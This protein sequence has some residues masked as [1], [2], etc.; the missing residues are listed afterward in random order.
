MKIKFITKN[1][2]N[3]QFFVNRDFQIC[4]TKETEVIIFGN[5]FT[6]NR[7]VISPDGDEMYCYVSPTG[8]QKNFYKWEKAQ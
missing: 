7:I 6:V 2:A 8:A 5:Y 1:G 4:P 3:E